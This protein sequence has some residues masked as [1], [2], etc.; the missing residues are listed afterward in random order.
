MDWRVKGVLQKVLG[1]VPGGVLVNDVLQRAFGEL[2]DFDAV[3]KNKV[4]DD[5][6]VLISHMNELKINP[7]D[8][9]YVEIGT[10]WMPTLPVC[11]ALVGARACH[12]F[13]L[14]RHLKEDLTLRMVQALATHLP[15]I[16]Q[17][18]SRPSAEIEAV[19]AALAQARNAG[20]LLRLARIEYNAPADAAQ[21]GLAD[22]SVDIVFSNSVF[23]HIGEKALARIMRETYRILKPGGLAIHSVNC[24]DHYAYFDREITFLNYLSYTEKEWAFWNNGMLYQN[25]LR[26]QRFLDLARE[27]GLQIVLD[28]QK[29]KPELMALLPKMKVA[30]EFAH[31][32]PEQ[33]CCS[34]IDFVAK[35]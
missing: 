32:P 5:W 33:L 17:A 31:M 35:R 2:R 1:A 12:T 10:G 3:V 4:V 26:P 29:P 21:T 13:D 25:R 8:L 19:H 30:A 16:A 20:D 27:A 14:N 22:G 11:Y 7:R 6:L 34:S 18:V 24:G 23:E 28:K 15:A 9:V